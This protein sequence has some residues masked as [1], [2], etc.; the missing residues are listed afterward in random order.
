MK[1]SINTKNIQELINTSKQLIVI[2]FFSEQSG[3]SFIMKRIL[4]KV[5]KN[6]ENDDICFFE[7]DIDKDDTLAKELNIKKTP[8]IIIYRDQEIR[9]WLKGI[10]SN[11]NLELTLNVMLAFSTISTTQEDKMSKA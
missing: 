10:I 9:E 2:S 6:F 11:E 8:T 1:T 4:T 7:I 3:G 5:K